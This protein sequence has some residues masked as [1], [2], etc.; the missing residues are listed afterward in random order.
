[1]RNNS[2][3]CKD[4]TSIFLY[5]KSNVVS[6]IKELYIRKCRSTEWERLIKL[7]KSRNLEFELNKY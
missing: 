1:M 2:R 6:V 4:M 3:N 7:K 5:N